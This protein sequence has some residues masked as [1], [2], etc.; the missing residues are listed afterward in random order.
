[1]RA[2]SFDD[3]SAA[4]VDAAAS[5]PRFRLNIEIHTRILR[6]FAAFG[7]HKMEKKSSLHRQLAGLPET[8]P[9]GRS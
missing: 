1:M 2:L 6:D 7:N 3:K 5:A 4:G 9:P 8:A